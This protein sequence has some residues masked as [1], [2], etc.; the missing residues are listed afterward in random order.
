MAGNYVTSD[1]KLK[2]EGYDWVAVIVKQ[3]SDSLVNISVRSRADKEKPTCTFDANATRID[4]KGLY[5]ASTNG[6]SV[7]FL[8]AGDSLIIKSDPESTYSNLNYFCSGGASIEGVYSKLSEPLD[9]AQIDKVLFRK[10]LNY[11]KFN[12]L[13]EVYGKTL[14]IE[15]VG[16]TVDNQTVTHKIEGTVMNAEIGDLNGDGFPEVLVYIQSVG[17]GSYGSVICY[18]V[19]NGKS[20]SMIHLPNVA[21][22]P[23]I[24]E[25]YMG[26]DEFAIVENTFVQR[27]PVYKSGDVN[28][29]PT[30]GMRQVHYKLKDGEA[31][32]QFVVDK[33]VEDRF[34]V[35]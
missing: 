19:N 5:K 3:L 32:R 29:K 10:S 18:S 22:N 13:I 23:E 28:A 34:L 27:F 24:N 33:I 12:F 15:P 6:N 20:M 31:L 17:S 35:R 4:S 21:E 1:Y 9:T 7:L 30:G 2:D 11:D 8:F 26:H 25:G 14:T 16:L